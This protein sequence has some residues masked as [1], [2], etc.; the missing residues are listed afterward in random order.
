MSLTEICKMVEEKK[1]NKGNCLS[2]F[3]SQVLTLAVQMLEW[4]G[5]LHGYIFMS[6]Q[7]NSCI[8]NYAWLLVNLLISVNK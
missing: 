4:H 8:H 6:M 1:V 3:C 5:T 7:E 2:S